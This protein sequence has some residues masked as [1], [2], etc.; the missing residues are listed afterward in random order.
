MDPCNSFDIALENL[1]AMILAADPR[2][3]K[4]I[5]HLQ[6]GLGEIVHSLAPSS[7]PAELLLLG[8]SGLQNIE[9]L[10][11]SAVLSAVATAVA[12]SSQHF[13]EANEQSLAAIETASAG[14]RELLSPSEGEPSSTEEQNAPPSDASAASAAGATGLA[15]ISLADWDRELLPEYLVESREHIA[16]AESAILLLEVT[17]DDAESINTVLR[18]FHTVKGSSGLLRLTLIQTLA[19]QAENLLTNARDGVIRMDRSNINLALQSC[20][21]IKFIV[22]QLEALPPGSAPTPPKNMEKLLR[23]LSGEDDFKVPGGDSATA[24]S[25]PA[26]TPS[27]NAVHKQS[28]PAEQKISAGASAEKPLAK[29]NARTLPESSD[30]TTP[31]QT[32]AHSCETSIRVNAARLDDLFNMVGEL[33]IAQS[34]VAQD[35]QLVEA[36]HG[37][38]A[39]SVAHAGKIVRQLQDLTMGLSMVPFKATFQKMSRIARDLTQKSEKLIHFQTSGENTEIDRNMVQ[40]LNDPLMHLIRNAV[41]HGIESPADRIR[42]GKPSEG[43]LHLRAYH[44]AGNVVIELEDDGQGLDSEKILRRAVEHG[45]VESDRAVS[46]TEVYSL[47]FQPGFSTAENITEVSGRGVGLD[48]VQ[49]NVESL[50][51]HVS[52]T[53]CPGKSTKFTVTVPLTTAILEAMLL[54]VGGQR[55]LLPTIAILRSFRPQPGSISTVAG[56]AEMVMLHDRLFPL[57]RLDKLFNIPDAITDPFQAMVVIIEGAGKQCALMVDEILGQQQ[58]VIK[59]LGNALASVSGVAGGAIMGDGNVGIILDAVGLVNIIHNRLP[60]IHSCAATNSPSQN[61]TNSFTATRSYS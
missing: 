10:E 36:E 61:N 32:A 51:G 11:G 40:V 50:R 38:L 46:A 7:P 12:A 17:P 6:D 57:F 41:D 43:T 16:T 42:C 27:Y 18:A 48:V 28:P 49:R 54:R 20:D 58:V 21:A 25:Q 59:S 23:A 47:I 31:S 26:S 33:V 60:N 34:I 44:D 22:D 24:A 15:G 2:D 56:R 9:K 5:A 29:N 19:H 14:I 53:S 1:N 35:A 8:L 37:R 45:L 55:Y 39:H 3:R 13:R 4:T 52:V 30:A